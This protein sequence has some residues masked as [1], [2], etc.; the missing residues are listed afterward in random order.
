[1]KAETLFRD[2][3]FKSMNY[4]GIE[5]ET[6]TGS[7]LPSI[8]EQTVIVDNVQQQLQVVLGLLYQVPWLRSCMYRHTHRN[9]NKLKL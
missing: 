3:N 5:Q 8:L 7:E 4:V 2:Q 6:D 9:K 1:M